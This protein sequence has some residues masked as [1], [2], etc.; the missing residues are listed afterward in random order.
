MRKGAQ[1]IVFCQIAPTENMIQ[2]QVWCGESLKTMPNSLR[3]GTSTTKDRTTTDKKKHT[4]THT[5][6]VRQRH[7]H[8][9]THTLRVRRKTSIHG[10]PSLNQ[11]VH[12]DKTM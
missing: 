12:H 10:K 9:H 7:A 5:H 11:L 1:Q 2:K 8:T 6:T 3:S 4:H